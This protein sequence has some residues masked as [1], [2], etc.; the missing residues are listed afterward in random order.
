MKGIVITGAAG[1][2]GAALAA[3]FLRL[4]WRVTGIDRAAHFP[5][6]LTEQP[7]FKGVQADVTDEPALEASLGDADPIDAVMANA[8]VT[9][10]PHRGTLDLPYA[11]W[12]RIQRVNVDG[13]FLTARCAARRMTTGGNIIFV[14][15][16]LAR[17]SDAR[18]GDGPYCTSK[19]AVE[20][21][22]RVM[23]LE[24][25]DRGINV[26]TLFPSV[27][28]DT[29]FFSHWPEAERSA[30]HPPTILNAP[31]AWLA[32]LDPGAATGR[33][34]DQNRWDADPAYRADWGAP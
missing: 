32:N 23:A 29:G 16:S 14:T 10:P 4:D 33:S 1:G 17:L 31:A 21:L 18:A 30:L 24:L 6:A 22:A 12:A 25:A 34:L 7:A 9:D 8:A 15:S 11:D 20:M 5:A 28:I 2:I 27:M 26:N 13:G 3:H 19:A